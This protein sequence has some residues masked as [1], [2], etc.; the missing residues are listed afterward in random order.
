MEIIPYFLYV[1]FE[2][3]NWEKLGW[4]GNTKNVSEESSRIVYTPSGYRRH[5]LLGKPIVVSG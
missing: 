3:D 2:I 5:L 4:R 1:G